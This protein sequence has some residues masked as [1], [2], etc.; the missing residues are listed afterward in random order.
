MPRQMI[1]T[2][3]VIAGFVV[4]GACRSSVT[5]YPAAVTAADGT[6][7]ATSYGRRD[8]QASE[9]SPMVSMRQGCSVLA[10]P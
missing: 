3:T 1:L 2:D 8:T 10:R 9:P 4:G 5:V 6:D 7:Q